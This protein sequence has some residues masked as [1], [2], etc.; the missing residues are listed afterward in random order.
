MAVTPLLLMH[1]LAYKNHVMFLLL[2]HFSWS[3]IFYFVITITPHVVV[4]NSAG[5]PPPPR[6]NP[7]VTI[8]DVTLKFSKIK[9]FV[10]SY[11]SRL[12]VAM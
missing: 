8:Y 5:A 9:F 12:S 3:N 6:N 10:L 2:G 1:N 11:F 7:F 4:R